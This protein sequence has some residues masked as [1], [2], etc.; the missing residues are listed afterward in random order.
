MCS[1][2]RRS[3]RPSDAPV[4][5]QFD[6]YI[7][8]NRGDRN[9]VGSIERGDSSGSLVSGIGGSQCH[10]VGGRSRTSRIDNGFA[11][12]TDSRHEKGGHHE[13]D[14]CGHSSSSLAMM[15]ATEETVWPS[16]TVITRTPVAARPWEEMLR[17]WVRM[18][19]PPEVTATISSSIPAMNADTT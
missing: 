7:V 2:G 19:A 14:Q 9:L 13:G 16:S 6:Q 11:E 1:R 18:V 12:T 5:S 4:H 8:G 17:T 3:P 10:C 15:S